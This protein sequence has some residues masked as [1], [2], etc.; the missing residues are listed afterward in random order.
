M[1]RLIILFSLLCIATFGNAG[2]ALVLAFVWI[3][4]EVIK[5]FIDAAIADINQISEHGW[6]GGND[7]D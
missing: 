4:V 3:V 1:I 2:I 6:F 5:G 7:D